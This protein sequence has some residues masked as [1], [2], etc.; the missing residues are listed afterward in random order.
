MMLRF[1]AF[2]CTSTTGG[3]AI[4]RDAAAPV[5]PTTVPDSGFSAPNLPTRIRSVSA[6]LKT[7]SP[8]H[9]VFYFR[10]G[11]ITI[12]QLKRVRRLR[13]MAKVV[14]IITSHRPPNAMHIALDVKI[15]NV[16]I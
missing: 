7:F 10:L 3:V 1:V 13:T 4:L 8:L 9:T 14:I 5:V 6:P 11:G 16:P 2:I 15:F 12:A